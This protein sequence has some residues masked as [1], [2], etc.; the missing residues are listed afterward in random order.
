MMSLIFLV[1]GMAFFA[2]G[3]V[4]SRRPREAAG[5]VSKHAPLL[6]RVAGVLAL[7]A[8]VGYAVTGD[9]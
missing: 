9:Q 3:G 6:F 1:L 2:M 8:A 4:Y 5:S 7:A